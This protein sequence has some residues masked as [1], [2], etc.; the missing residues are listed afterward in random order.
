MTT[1]GYAR[2]ST[3]GQNLATQLEALNKVG[4]DKVI[5]E[6]VSG[7][8]KKKP[9]LDALLEALQDG[10]TL[11]VSR[12]DRLGRSTLQLL[13]LVEELNAR[14]VD[15]VLLDM[16]VDTR[17]RTGKMMLT[18]LAALAENERELIKEKQQEGIALAKQAGKY[19]GS[20]KKYGDNNPKMIHAL[21]LYEAGETVSKI[22]KITEI[23]KATLYR[24]LKELNITRS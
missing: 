19:K 11:V 16:N 13:T 9:Q 17:T 15:L 12:M 6:K 4:V 7:V 23:S 21:E 2:V 3:I 24:R 1:Y 18:I 14:G 20:V 22:T 5:K 8:S 10:D